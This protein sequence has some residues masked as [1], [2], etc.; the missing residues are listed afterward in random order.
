MIVR[1][2]V[3]LKKLINRQNNGAIKVITGLRRSG[4]SFLLFNLFY[5]Y[6]K[7]QGVD[8]RHLIC[9]SF[10][11]D[12]HEELLDPKE[13]GKFVRRQLTDD[14]QYYLFLDEIQFVPNFSK[15]LNGLGKIQ[16]LDIYVTGS[17]SR[18]L[19]SDI[20]TEFRG[21]GDEVR[22]YPLSFAEYFSVYDGNERDAWQDYIRYGGMPMIVNQKTD[23]QRANYLKNLFRK[24]YI[25]DIVE[26]NNLRGNMVLENVVRILAS[27]VGSLTN[28]NKLAKTFNSNGSEKIT[29]KTVATYIEHLS[30]AFLINCSERY[31]VKGKHY[32]ASPFKYYFTDVGVRNACLNFRQ[33]EE[34]HLMENV[35]Y[36]E[37][38]YRGFNVDVG[39]VL[40]TGKTSENKNTTVRYEIDF[41]CNQASQR[42]YIQSALTVAEAEKLIQE[43]RSLLQA[44]DAFKKVIITRDDVKPWY[45]EH[46]ILII[47]VLDF[48]LEKYPFVM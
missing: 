7:E 3:Y 10:D 17:N 5:K 6:L 25:D 18:F 22:V 29:D 45:D 26:R 44:K 35:L 43:E 46:G 40:G 47:N 37:L 13:L 12:E 24:V 15:V 39:V 30:D 33:H 34:N 14:G 48:L 16:N 20:L 32:I 21:R 28:P 23:E 27:D 19:S 42:Y 8:D 1:R 2:D 41:V 4:K 38:L 31:D 11:D 9:L 36:N